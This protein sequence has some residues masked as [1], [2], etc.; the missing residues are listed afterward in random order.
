MKLSIVTT[1]YQ[2]SRYMEEFH[3]RM[4][5]TARAIT[6]DY[7][8]V[9]VNDGSP[10]DSL[11]VAKKLLAGDRHIVIV[12]LSRNFG[13]HRAMMT[14]LERAE[15]EYVF[16]IDVDL[17]EH[18]ENLTAFWDYLSAHAEADVVIGELQTKKQGGLMRRLT[19]SWFWNLFNFLS[20]IKISNR[21]LI[22]RLMR[23]RYIDSLISYQ[24]R[25]LFIPGVWAHAGYNQHYLPA[26]KTF[27]GHSTYTLRRRLVMAVDAIASFSSKPLLMVFYTGV[28]FVIGAALAILYLS[29]RKL[30][31]GYGILGWASMVSFLFFIGGVI[32]FS[33]GIVGMYIA[34]IY[35][36][37][38]QRPNSIIKTIYRE[39]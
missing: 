37:V 16:L 12:D 8:L 38:K 31:Y 28:L 13:H 21:E 39:E 19:S 25:E 34:K 6:D 36:E 17:E 29:F 33:L 2:S 11:E 35:T 7:E 23:R 26:E 1:L 32:I 18:P 9:F 10:D 5:A 24:E 20:Y 3:H 4:T 30:V 27:D 22:S 15:G 14:G